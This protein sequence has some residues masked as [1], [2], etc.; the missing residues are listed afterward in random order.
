MKLLTADYQGSAVSFRD[1]GW[2]NATQAARKYGKRPN[3]WL[4]LAET[5]DYIA[6]LNLFSN[7]G[8]NGIW[9]VS[10]RGNN[11]G[12]WLH[13]KLAVRFAQWL[14]VR[15]AVWC[16]MQID[17]IL[18]GTAVRP[19][20]ARRGLRQKSLNAPIDRRG[21]HHAAVDLMVEHKLSF[22]KIFKLFGCYAG[23]KRLDL[24][25][26]RCIPEVE[27]FAQRARVRQTSD[28]DWARVEAGR[29]MLAEDSPQMEL[30]A[31]S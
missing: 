19:R 7:T 13:P 31:Q 11:G 5:L 16:D 27:G 3:D 4:M 15:F 30:V 21:L 8:Q 22:P 28:E 17:A 29:K 18:R 25:E 14:D 10:K 6:A 24:I 12:T 9:Q 23:V 1:D 20:I 26:P 2:F